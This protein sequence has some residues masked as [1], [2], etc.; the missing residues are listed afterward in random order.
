MELCVICFTVLSIHLSRRMKETKLYEYV[1]EYMDGDSFVKECDGGD[2]VIDTDALSRW[3]T[4]IICKG[5]EY[6]K[7]LSY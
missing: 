2:E 1:K 6:K 7:V 4:G 5:V 3:C